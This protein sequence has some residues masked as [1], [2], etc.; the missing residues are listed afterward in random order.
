MRSLLRPAYIGLTAL[1][2]GLDGLLLDSLRKPGWSLLA[3]VLSVGR[4]LNAPRGERLRL[5]LEHLGPIFV[6][7]GQMLSTRRD[8]LPPDVADELA[9]LQ[10]RVPP[11]PSD[12]SARLVE[13]ALG[14]PLSAVFKTV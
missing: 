3:R 7:F 8:L 2:F 14:K 11:F 9:R 12:E 10:D 5:A 1:R 6:K 4:R 13:K